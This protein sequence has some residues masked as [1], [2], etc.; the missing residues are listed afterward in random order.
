MRITKK[1]KVSNSSP[2]ED[3]NM[4]T[5]KVVTPNLVETSEMAPGK[6]EVKMADEIS[7]MIQVT[8]G[9]KHHLIAE[10]A[11]YRAE[12]RSFTPGNELEDW[13]NAEAEIET[14]L[15]KNA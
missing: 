10:A 7:A 6:A 1:A 9:E 14:I 15:T 8:S 12:Q 11:Y 4:K 5:Q 2:K 13:L 3:F